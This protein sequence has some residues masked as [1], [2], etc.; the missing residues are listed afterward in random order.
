MVEAD[1]VVPRRGAVQPVAATL[2]AFLLGG[3]PPPG[4]GPKAEAGYRRAAPVIDALDR[5]H[6]ARG[7]YPETLA[8]LVPEWLPAASEAHP[9]GLGYV[10]HGEH[11]KLSF[12]YGG[13][14]VN[15]CLYDTGATPPSSWQ[16]HG[17]Y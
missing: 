15:H 7:S 17:Y 9:L 3:C 13:P 1:R 12:S 10:R 4:Q 16:C 6:Q 5:Y 8:A 11:Y 2:L 14:G